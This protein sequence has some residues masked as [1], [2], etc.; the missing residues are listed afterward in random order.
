VFENSKK[1]LIVSPHSDDEAFGCGGLITKLK[2]KVELDFLLCSSD[3]M[4]FRDGV[5]IEGHKRFQEFSE[6]VSYVNGSVNILSLP[7]TQLKCHRN[8]ITNGIESHIR[9]RGID[10]LIFPY[11]S[12][13][14]DHQAVYESCISVLRPRNCPSIKLSLCYEIIN[15]I[16]HTDELAFNPNIYVELS[17]EE[18][19]EKIKLCNMYKS[20]IDR[21]GSP[22]VLADLI[23]NAKRRGFECEKDF[24]EAFKLIRNT[25]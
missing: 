7:D 12:F 23:E 1:V 6:L 25:I 2:G 21:P 19:Q 4:I 3:G 17:K 20:Q 9:K 24:A 5:F 11:K 22:I 10:T 16:W 15:Y 8:R 18:V 13:H 14:Q